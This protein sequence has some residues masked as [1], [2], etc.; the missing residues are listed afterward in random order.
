[1]LLHLAA[2]AIL[3]Y[4]CLFA[5]N[6][7]ASQARLGLIPSMR[8]I[9]PKYDG[10]ANQPIEARANQD[11]HRHEARGKHEENPEKYTTGTPLQAVAA[12]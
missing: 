8:L 2:P 3:K 1:L 11:N 7:I 10:I 4:P 6:H 9:R 12:F 5:K